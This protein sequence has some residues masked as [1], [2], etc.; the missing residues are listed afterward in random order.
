VVVVVVPPVVVVV[1]VPPHIA[2]SFARVSEPTYPE[3]GEM[4]CLL[5]N[6]ITAALVAGPKVE[7]S[8]PGEPAPEAATIVLESLF[9]NTWRA[10][11]SAP[12]EPTE[13]LV[14]HIAEHEPVE[15]EG[16]EPV[17]AWPL[18]DAVTLATVVASAP[19]DWSKDTIALTCADVSAAARAGPAITPNKSPRATTVP[20]ATAISRVEL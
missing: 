17:V 20:A 19:K 12:L 7:L 4:P 16:V 13:R 15:V 8:I 14:F 1:V 6:F 9:K 3:A 5:W 2:L 18:S 10:I 11:T